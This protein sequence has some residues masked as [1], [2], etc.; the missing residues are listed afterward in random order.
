MTLSLILTLVLGFA[1]LGLALMWS[2][3]P[4]W[5][6]ALLTLG[7]TAMYF[8]SYQTAM[9]LLGIP[10]TEALPERFVM[11]AAVVEEPRGKSTGAV[12]LWVSPMVEE[13]PSRLQPRAYKLPYTKPLHQ[14]IN[15]GLKKGREGVSQMGSAELRDG[16]GKGSS[17]LS[18][19][20]D[21]QEIKIRDLPV[22]QLPEK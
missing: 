16:S 22:P 13:G 14:Q 12:Y 3:W 15:D 17:W 10:S 9:A 4:R 2:A 18:P 7:I 1:L 21:E 5:L 8:S 20:N 19:G 6:K 11:L